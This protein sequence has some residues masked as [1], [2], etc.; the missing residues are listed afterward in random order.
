VGVLVGLVSTALVPASVAASGLSEVARLN[1]ASVVVDGARS[2]L[3]GDVLSGRYASALAVCAAGIVL[4]QVA[5]GRRLACA[6][7]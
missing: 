1:P 3:S 2:S 6:S 7:S 5:A 4:A